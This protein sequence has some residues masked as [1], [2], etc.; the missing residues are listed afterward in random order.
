MHCYLLAGTDAVSKVD[1]A[2]LLTRREALGVLDRLSDRESWFRPI[3]FACVPKAPL[4]GWSL[5]HGA[6]ALRRLEF[7]V[8]G[9]EEPRPCDLLVG[10]GV[11]TIRLWDMI[12]IRF[13]QTFAAGL[14][15]GYDDSYV[16]LRGLDELVADPDARRLYAAKQQSFLVFQVDEASVA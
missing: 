3:E 7:V 1:V 6:S 9:Y 5:L 16:T 4:D 8:V 13:L 11:L 14:V 12:L 10:E 2:L 15:S